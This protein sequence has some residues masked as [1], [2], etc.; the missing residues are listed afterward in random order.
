MPKPKAKKKKPIASAAAAA[1]VS[2]PAASQPCIDA[3][4]AAFIVGGCL[5]SGTHEN[6]DT[7]EQT[8][9]I[10]ENLRLIF[11]ECVFNG[12]TNRGCDITRG[13][14]PN[15]ATTTVG[16]VQDAIIKNAH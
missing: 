5:P 1:A 8:G 9:L 13:Q 4:D 10:S 11:R 7:L 6:D 2:V 16:E 12:V 15:G 3:L 14:I